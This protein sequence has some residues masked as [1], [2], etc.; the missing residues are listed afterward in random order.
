MDGI[1]VDVDD[2]D[3][4]VELVL[5]DVVVVNIDVVEVDVVEVVVADR[6]AYKKS[7]NTKTNKQ[8]STFLFFMTHSPELLRVFT[9]N[10]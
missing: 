8:T 4:D 1:V 6:S 7:T 5:V 2:V 9:Y 10:K 3:D